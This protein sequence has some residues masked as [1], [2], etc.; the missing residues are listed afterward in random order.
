MRN[1]QSEGQFNPYAIPSA[2]KPD[3]SMP[4]YDVTLDM[5]V[6][7]KAKG[8]PVQKTWLINI[9]RSSHND[10][11]RNVEKTIEELERGD[12]L[13]KNHAAFTEIILDG[14]LSSDRELTQITTAIGDGKELS[15]IDLIE[16]HVG[17]LIRAEEDSLREAEDKSAKGKDKWGRT[18]V[19]KPFLEEGWREDVRYYRA[20]HDLL[21]NLLEVVNPKEDPLKKLI[22]NGLV[23]PT[24]TAPADITKNSRVSGDIYEVSV[25]PEKFARVLSSKKDVDLSSMRPLSSG[26]ADYFYLP[27]GYKVNEGSETKTYYWIM[28]KG[29]GSLIALKEKGSPFSERTKGEIEGS[30]TGEDVELDAANSKKLRAGDVRVRIPLGIY[31]L[32]SI[33][34]DGKKYTPEE[35]LSAGIITKT[36]ESP[37]I[38]VFAVGSPLKIEDV[39]ETLKTH[40]IS[41]SQTDALLKFMAA[42]P[43]GVEEYPLASVFYNTY[44]EFSVKAKLIPD[45]M[46]LRMIEDF[47]RGFSEVL[48]RQIAR[49]EKLS[50]SIENKGLAAPGYTSFG[51]NITT[52]VEFV[53]N[54]GVQFGASS[55]DI[56]TCQQLF[57][58]L[59]PEIIRHVGL[60]EREYNGQV[61][62]LDYFLFENYL[63][64]MMPDWE[65]VD[66]PATFFT[67]LQEI[68]ITTLSDRPEI[69]I[70]GANSSTREAYCLTKLKVEKKIA[71][72]GSVVNV[73]DEDMNE[74]ERLVYYVFHDETLAKKFIEKYKANFMQTVGTS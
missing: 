30:A 11:L 32:Q 39:V 20:R 68:L 57:Y 45:N 17:G 8:I 50:A 25:A 35:L 48:G 6:T 34:Y 66:I 47:A 55:T 38:G 15:V 71:E 19:G 31:S 61:A 49:L 67:E 28:T 5:L 23:V 1:D 40:G 54:S 10:T 16:K 74:I 9:L 52:A 63:K 69:D 7:N 29:S 59:A 64:E 21:N 33:E 36:E 22:E 41:S 12:I 42:T 14:T 72:R 60:S 2:L 53:D 26:R 73:S 56:N 13:E 24:N 37:G 51:N 3:L 58:D 44:K 43:A 46:R 18:S 65:N 62:D 27:G 70:S 4:S